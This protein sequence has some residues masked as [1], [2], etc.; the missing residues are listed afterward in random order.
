MTKQSSTSQ[1][2]FALVALILLCPFRAFA[3][4][5]QTIVVHWN[6]TALRAIRETHTAPPQAARM[7]AMTHTCMYDAWAA[8][9]RVATGTHWTSQLRRPPSEATTG[10]K[11]KAISYASYHCLLDLLPRERS[12]F[13]QQMQRLGYD[14][15]NASTD[16]TTAAGIGNTTA[17]EV[18]K[19]CHHDGAN[20]LGDLAPGEYH[21]YSG[22]K[23]VNG[24][25]HL[26]N[27]DRWQPLLV[28][29]RGDL[30]M[31]HFL[32]PFWSRVAPFA[33]TSADQ[34]RPSPPY[35]FK[36]NREAYIQQAMD[37]ID[38]SANLT[39]RQKVIAEYWDDGPGSETP[40]GHW[41]R[42]AQFV[43]SRDH[44]SLDADAKMFFVL[45]NAILDASIATWDAKRTY[46]S[47]RP[48]TAIRFLFVGK[49]FRAWGGPGEGT[50]EIDGAEWKPYQ[51]AGFVTPPFPEYVSGHS[52]FSAAAAEAMRLFTGSDDFG[53]STM[54]K[55]GSSGIE[56]G[57]V[58]S[59]DVVLSWAT[60]TDAA[61]QAGM[62]RRYGGIHFKMADLNGRKL[63]RAVGAQA[64]TKALS[65]FNLPAGQATLH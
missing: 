39:D 62:S 41:C 35:T 65:Y 60:F 38:I 15:A 54:V 30:M 58:P 53:M 61:D 21:D 64:F 56:P 43:S 23:P 18:I 8:Y 27:P 45:T 13:N 47:V 34:F 46:D 37:L 33:L 4:A 1:I 9:D 49:K 25:A 29:N 32:V 17:A 26:S 57:K 50:K 20:Q 16:L 24:P 14:P 6:S 40:S 55:A 44:H 3:F 31:Q 59:Q 28:V 10:N 11:E 48:I 63:G 2:R 19:G 5:S 52:T 7:L 36:E 22:Y 42:I 51:K 12:L